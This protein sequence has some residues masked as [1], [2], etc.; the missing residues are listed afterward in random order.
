MSQLTIQKKSNHIKH[1]RRTR[2]L[3]GIKKLPLTPNKLQEP[4]ENR[5]RR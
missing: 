3:V 5:Q 1:Q 2:E 4:S